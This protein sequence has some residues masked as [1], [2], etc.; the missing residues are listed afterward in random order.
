MCCDYPSRPSQTGWKTR[1]GSLGRG[2]LIIRDCTGSMMGNKL[3][4][5]SHQRARY[6][7]TSKALALHPSPR[8]SHVLAAETSVTWQTVHRKVDTDKWLG[9]CSLARNAE[10]VIIWNPVTL[11]QIE[12]RSKQNLISGRL[13]HNINVNVSNKYITR[14]TLLFSCYTNICLMINRSLVVAAA[15]VIRSLKTST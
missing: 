1:H 15:N 10:N 9:K 14:W 3:S 11:E 7:K 12:R 13:K 5:I 4:V 6:H 8:V 2:T